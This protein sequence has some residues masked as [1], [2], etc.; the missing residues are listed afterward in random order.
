MS[1]FLLLGQF[2]TLLGAAIYLLNHMLTVILLVPKQSMWCYGEIVPRTTSFRQLSKQLSISEER[3]PYQALH[4]NAVGLILLSLTN[5]VGN[6]V[7]LYTQQSV[8]E[9]K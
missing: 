3:R 4:I 8:T 6:R 1:C 2:L 9:E 7:T 5:G